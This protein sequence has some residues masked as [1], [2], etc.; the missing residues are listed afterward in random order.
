MLCEK[1]GYN[2]K[3]IE[4]AANILYLYQKGYTDLII[5][6]GAD[7]VEAFDTLFNQYNGVFNANGIGYKFNSINKYKYKFIY[8]K[9]TIIFK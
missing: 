4:W 2:I 5:V 9:F 7:R 8:V 1:E 6:V 3:I